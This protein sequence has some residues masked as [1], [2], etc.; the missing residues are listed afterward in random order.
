MNLKSSAPGAEWITAP[1][2]P[3]ASSLGITVACAGVTRV[4]EGGRR[5]SGALVGTMIQPVP[6]FLGSVNGPRNVAP[7]SS[8][9]TSPGW[10]ALSAAWTLPP[11]RT[12]IVRPMDRTSLV[13][14]VA[15][16][17]SGG[18]ASTATTQSPSAAARRIMSVRC[19]RWGTG[20]MRWKGTTIE[21]CDAVR[22][23]RTTVKRASP[24]A[25]RLPFYALMFF[26]LVVLI[27]PQG[28][29]PAL[30]PLHLA[31]V[32]AAVAAVAHVADRMSR[33]RPP[34][35]M[36]PEVLL[37][38]LLFALGILSVPTSYWPRGSVETLL[39]LL[40]KSLILLLLLANI[41]VTAERL[42]TMLW[43]LAL[44]STVPALAVVEA[45]L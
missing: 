8:V 11:A 1:A 21:M 5:L 17:R 3:R 22:S 15:R 9:I 26:T 27:A 20:R 31:L 32:A 42:R 23:S 41:L 4:P 6:F 33:S 13:S 29:V 16:G 30:A 24:P 28:L 7:A 37:A 12:A 38:L 10:A 19:A 34:T 2:P 40:G 14:T 43:L 45:Y 44:G 35:V 39:T 25:A 36:E 18:A